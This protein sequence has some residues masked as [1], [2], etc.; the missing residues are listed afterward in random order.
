M[1]AAIQR[2]HAF[3]GFQKCSL[4]KQQQPAS[5]AKVCSSRNGFDL[6]YNIS[7]TKYENILEIQLKY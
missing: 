3:S 5:M 7:D 2:I 4:L 1:C 6:E